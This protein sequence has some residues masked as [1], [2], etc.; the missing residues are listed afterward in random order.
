MFMGKKKRKEKKK[1][2]ELERRLASLS[3]KKT[4]SRGDLMLI[5]TVIWL[6]GLIVIVAKYGKLW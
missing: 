1:E 3:K 4:I 6:L 5:V 2:V